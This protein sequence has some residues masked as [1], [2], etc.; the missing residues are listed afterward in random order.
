MKKVYISNENTATLTCPQCGKSKV[1]DTSKYKDREGPV[2]I[3]FTFKCRKCYCGK[4]HADGCD[5]TDCKKGHEMAAFL[6]RR[7]D[8]RK[9]VD[10]PG[11]V[12]D[13]LKNEAQIKVRDISK[14]GLLLE[15]VTPKT[16]EIGETLTVSFEQDDPKQTKIEK[17]IV[18]RKMIPPNLLGVEFTS[19]DT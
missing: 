12:I 13:G 7:R 9:K 10:L 16:F 8:H 15:I 4:E 2:K 17:I 5:G 11:K 18:I 6:E 3:K 14:K 19:S 1:I